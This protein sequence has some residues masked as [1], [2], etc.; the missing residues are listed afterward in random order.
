M[1]RKKVGKLAKLEKFRNG[2]SNPF[3]D[4][5]LRDWSSSEYSISYD[6]DIGGFGCVWSLRKLKGKNNMPSLFD[7]YFKR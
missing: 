3:L 6:L 4:S 1:V 7:W 5:A 2:S